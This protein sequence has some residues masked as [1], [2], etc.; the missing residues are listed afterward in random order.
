MEYTKELIKLVEL[1]H[2]TEEKLS[3]MI[4]DATSDISVSCNLAYWLKELER[5]I[6]RENPRTYCEQLIAD[7]ERFTDEAEAFQCEGSIVDEPVLT[8][9]AKTQDKRIAS[10]VADI[11][12]EL[13]EQVEAG[14]K[15]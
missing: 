4:L 6:A 15:N 3:S 14:I 13:A 2:V 9:W 7:A 10:V 8:M 11:F 12:R 5:A 1:C